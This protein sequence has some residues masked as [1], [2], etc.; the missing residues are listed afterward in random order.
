MKSIEKR[1][2]DKKNPLEF[3]DFG[4]EI[5]QRSMFFLSPLSADAPLLA[6]A[7]VVAFVPRV[8]AHV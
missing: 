2:G 4:V 6:V 8:S 5:F 7:V 1:G 3:S